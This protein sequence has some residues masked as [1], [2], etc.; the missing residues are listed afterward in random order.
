MRPK[1]LELKSFGPFKSEHINFDLLNNHKLFLIS[2]KTGAG[3][4]TIFDGMMYALFGVASTTDRLAS[5]LR[6]INAND[7][8]PTEVIYNFYIKDRQYEIYRDLPFYKTGNTSKKNT[9]LEVYE[10]IN[11]ERK[12]LATGIKEGNAIIQSIIKLNAQQFRKIF[13]LPQ[14]EFKSLLIANSSEKMEILRSLF[15]TK[16]IEDLI[17]TLKLKVQND[18]QKL[19]TLESN[20]QAQLTQF[21]NIGHEMRPT[22]YHQQKEALNAIIKNDDNELQQLLKTR[23]TQLNVYQQ[24]VKILEDARLLQKNIQQLEDF[25]TE[26]EKLTL[27]SQSIEDNKI[28]IK[29]LQQLLQYKAIYHS[30]IEIENKNNT[31]NA[32]I[33]AQQE[34][35]K[36]LNEDL[37][38]LTDEHKQLNTDKAAMSNIHNYLIKTEGYLNQEFSTLN[39]RLDKLVN[40][41]EQLETQLKDLSSMQ[42]ATNSLA[43]KISDIEKKMIKFEN[44]IAK[45]DKQH[46]IISNLLN[47]CV[48]IKKQLNQIN[49]TY[50]EIN[51]MMIS[52]SDIVEQLRILNYGENI[53]DITAV[54]TIRNSLTVGERCPVCTNIVEKL[55]DTTHHKVHELQSNLKEIND[56]I[57]SRQMSLKIYIQGIETI[58]YADKL[59][60][61]D[62]N[63]ISVHNIDAI[64]R[65]L[66]AI[67]ADNVNIIM[68]DITILIEQVNT[69]SKILSQQISDE[70]KLLKQLNEQHI[71]F[72]EE[73]NAQ[74]DISEKY[75]HALTQL[76]STN[77][78]LIE[79]RKDHSNF[80]QITE[81]DAYH[82][83]E[84]H[85]EHQNT[86]YKKY[87]EAVDKNNKQ[88]QKLQQEFEL[89]SQK[90]EIEQEMVKENNTDINKLAQKLKQ[91]DIPEEI[92][93]VYLNKEISREIEDLENEIKQYQERLTQINH[94][95]ER[96]LMLTDYKE[97]PDISALEIEI[98][99]LN[100]EIENQNDII[101]KR[102]AQAKINKNNL[103]ILIQLLHQLEQHQE[104]SL[105]LIQLSNILSGNNPQKIDLESFVLMYYLEQTLI[106]SNI[107]LR[108]MTGN[109]YE[110]RRR[111]EKQG[112]GKQGLVIEVFDYN[113][114]KTRGIT[115]L[116]GGE[117]FLASLCL[118]L[119]LSDFVMQVAGGVHLESVF[120]DEGFGTLDSE[121]L[122][123]VINA[124]SDLQSSGKLVGIISHVQLLKERIPATLKIASNGFESNAD[125]EIK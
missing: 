49:D 92:I 55:D 125:F 60:A 121:T 85:F 82:L 8:E 9:T 34:K 32:Q 93:K 46:M 14:G 1:I 58:N 35:S 41:K 31:L 63:T 64:S 114:N 124:L 5:N 109:R 83:F 106:Q 36:L 105:S 24:R 37:N 108:A 10:I 120:I 116:S 115:S 52:K 122:E 98:D 100:K 15:E 19:Q 39:K 6:N 65:S 86:R 101:Y 90:L 112:G 110:L 104:A 56:K 50:L 53:Q 61:N 33:K 67:D 84:A 45:N 123:V 23:D 42:D 76:E 40:D 77:K 51:Q 72:K 17:K 71:Q 102:Q 27:K 117:S 66:E 80:K 13:I 88:L 54:D 89:L 103:D 18:Q 12:L 69:Y 73:Q 111:Q 81:F 38:A 99:E 57:K 11:G 30:K 48:K 25:K 59:I 87:R 26:K 2:G 7:N 113:A 94:D 62:D 95:I 119:G 70:Q 68:K 21:S 20:I 4:T 28:L 74:I 75:A 43:D 22:Q 16:K 96:L 91:F 3:K 118:A 78:S 97:M 29:N 47:Q 44:N 79:L 107:R